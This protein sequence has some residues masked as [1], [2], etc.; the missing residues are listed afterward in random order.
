MPYK[1][2]EKAFAAQVAP[3]DPEQKARLWNLK[4]A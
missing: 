1:D 3:G 4:T 2:W